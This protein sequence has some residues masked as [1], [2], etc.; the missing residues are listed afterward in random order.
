MMQPHIE[1]VLRFTANHLW[2][3]TL[4]AC[5]AATRVFPG[6]AAYNAS[7]HAALG[8]TNTLREELRCRSIRVIGLQAGATDTDI[9]ATLWPEAPRRKMISSGPSARKLKPRLG[10]SS[11]TVAHAV[12]EAILLP[13]KATVENLEILPSAG[14]L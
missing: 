1:T 7:K 8:F 6:S 11:D 10:S 14:T 9:W 2:Q 12:L 4:T 3:S 5:I 13:S